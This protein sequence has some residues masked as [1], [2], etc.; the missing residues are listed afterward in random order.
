MSPMT[1]SLLLLALSSLAL[2]ASKTTLKTTTTKSS[3]TAAPKST[4]YSTAEVA[5]VMQHD[6]KGHQSIWL[7]IDQV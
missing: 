4:V 7:I 1:H 3:T 6:Q 2:A 5:E